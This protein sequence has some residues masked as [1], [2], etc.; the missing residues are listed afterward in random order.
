M[1]RDAHLWDDPD[2]ASAPALLN[3]LLYL[4]PS[5]GSFPGSAQTDLWSRFGGMVA[6][7]WSQHAKWPMGEVARG[8]IDPKAEHLL[9]P[10]IRGCRLRWQQ[11]VL[12]W[13]VAR[14][15]EET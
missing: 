13:L 5:R 7:E 14:Q 11:T 9:F 10:H 4:R 2:D 12:R 6:G 15:I 3:R 1:G 8:D